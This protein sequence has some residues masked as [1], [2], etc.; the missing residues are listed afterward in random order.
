MAANTI[1]IE[2]N[3]YYSLLNQ[4]QKESVIKMLKSFVQGSADERQTVDEY[5][6]DIDKAIAEYKRGETLPHDVVEK[7]AKKW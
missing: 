5:N 2:F 7:M 6:A 1:D 4:S 3:K